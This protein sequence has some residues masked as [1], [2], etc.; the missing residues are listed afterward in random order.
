MFMRTAA[1]VCCALSTTLIGC[2]TGSWIGRDANQLIAKRGP[3]DLVRELGDGRRLLVYQTEST[4]VEYVATRDNCYTYQGNSYCS[5]IPGGTK[6]D[7]SYV[8]SEFFV[9]ADGKIYDQKW[10]QGWY[11]DPRFWPMERSS[12]R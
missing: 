9:G 12:R 8:T 4:T 1:V 11:P 6:R 5:I 3:P 7:P 2:A 10:H